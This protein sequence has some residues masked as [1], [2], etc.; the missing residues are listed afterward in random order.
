M[1]FVVGVFEGD[2][3][4]HLYVQHESPSQKHVG[5]KARIQTLQVTGRLNAVYCV[6]VESVVVY[7]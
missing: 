7:A 5:I 1:I 3:E 6:C 4:G 2:T